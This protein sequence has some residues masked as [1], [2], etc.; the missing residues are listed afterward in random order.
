MP[1]VNQGLGVGASIAIGGGGL[2]V[3]GAT[4]Y[5]RRRVQKNNQQ[6]FAPI[7][8]GTEE[9]QGIG[10]EVSASSWVNFEMLAL[11]AASFFKTKHHSCIERSF[12]MAVWS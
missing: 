10:L 4:I 1:N 8:A 9:S 6:D 12:H 2:L 5:V 7:D 11:V 3:I